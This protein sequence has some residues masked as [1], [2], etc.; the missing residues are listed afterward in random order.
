MRIGRFGGRRCFVCLHPV[1]SIVFPGAFAKTFDLAWRD[2]VAVSESERFEYHF[3]RKGREVGVS[4]LDAP[5][6]GR[7]PSVR[8][9]ATDRAPAQ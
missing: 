8:Q 1:V 9:A 2:N 3:T 5:A 4:S 6:V 7:S